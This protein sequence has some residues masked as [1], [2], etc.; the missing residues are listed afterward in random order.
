MGHAHTIFT[1]MR[2][3]GP[4][5]I[6]GPVRMGQASKWGAARIAVITLRHEIMRDLAAGFPASEIYRRH[7]NKLGHLT[8]GAFVRQVRLIVKTPLPSS[9]RKASNDG[10][11]P[12]GTFTHDPVVRADDRCELLGVSNDRRK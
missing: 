3:V 12:T 1:D 8:M 5:S 11:S 6:E 9:S 7:S 10:K 4:N 2:Q